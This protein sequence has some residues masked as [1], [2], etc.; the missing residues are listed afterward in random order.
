MKHFWLTGETLLSDKTI[1]TIKDHPWFS[2]INHK[3][4]SDS[5]ITP[6]SS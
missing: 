4:G 6:I 5:L 2:I 1:K 3:L